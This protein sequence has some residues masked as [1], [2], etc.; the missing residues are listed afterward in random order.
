MSNILKFTAGIKAERKVADDQALGRLKALVTDELAEVNEVILN[1]LQSQVAL[2]PEL[3]GHLISSGGKRLRPLMTLA[4]AK[5]VGYEGKRQCCLAACV[6]FIHTATLL[7]DDVVDASGLRRG[8]DTANVIWGNKPSVLVGDFVF[9]RAFE[10]M[11]E[12]GS[13]KILKILSRA[14]S[15][16][17]EGEV[18][19]LTTSNN[20]ESSEESYLKM[21]EAK[22][23]ALFAAACQ[24]SAVIAERPMVEEDALVSF[25]RN[26]GIAFQ[27]TDDAL[28]YS[29]HQATLG[30][31]VGDDFRD[32]KI[33]LPVLLA[34]GRGNDDERGFW[35]LVMSHGEQGD[36]DLEQAMSLMEKY[37]A[38]TD[39]VERARHYGAIAKDALA[40]FP[41]SEAKTAL[42]DI[43][44]FCIDRAY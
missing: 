17:A 16:L 13:L 39:T 28:D 36:N 11:V 18:L 6:E 9:S 14:S 29:A 23:A 12:D 27:L 25:G 33:T 4:S 44:D 34:Y 10:L 3:A 24:I 22:T 19:Q 8:L 30:K 43:T 21:I 41:R 32:G 35:R 26:F 15:I 42:L 1:R 31:A 2:I 40:I 20:P 38:L 37:S 7:H 5:L